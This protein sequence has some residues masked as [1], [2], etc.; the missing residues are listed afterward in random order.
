[1]ND[2]GEDVWASFAHQLKMRVLLNSADLGL[3]P[4]SVI[5]SILFQASLPL[6]LSIS[7]SLKWG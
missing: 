4:G 1:M 6:K 7:L 3:V 5:H 2:L